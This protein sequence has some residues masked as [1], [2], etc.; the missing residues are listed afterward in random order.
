[1]AKI[2][3][4]LLS[5]ISAA[6]VM[7]PAPASLHLLL[8][9]TEPAATTAPTPIRADPD[10][11]NISDPTDIVVL[12]PLGERRAYAPLDTVMIPRHFF[13]AWAEAEEG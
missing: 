9:F 6:T 11:G 4:S 5:A 2:T 13:G 3:Q 12:G 7:Q 1:M 8:G 10:A